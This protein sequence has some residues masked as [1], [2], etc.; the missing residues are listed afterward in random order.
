MCVCVLVLGAPGTILLNPTCL[1]ISCLSPCTCAPL[2]RTLKPQ[3][4]HTSML[5]LMGQVQLHVHSESSVCFC[6]FCSCKSILVWG[7]GGAQGKPRFSYGS[8]VSWELLWENWEEGGGGRE[9]CVALLPSLIFPMWLCIFV[10]DHV[11][12]CL[13]P[14][15]PPALPAID[16]LPHTSAPDRNWQPTLSHT[17]SKTASIP[18]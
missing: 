17:P 9:P 14:T 15:H 18:P 5:T 8:S 6:H 10:F 12:P 13:A 2:A 16:S 3:R 1:F 11:N 4:V 7:R